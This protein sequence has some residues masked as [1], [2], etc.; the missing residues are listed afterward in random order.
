[1]SEPR[2]VTV[3]NDARFNV[4]LCQPEDVDQVEVHLQGYGCDVATDATT[5]DALELLVPAAGGGT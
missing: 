5:L 3:A 1:M 4:P 2:L